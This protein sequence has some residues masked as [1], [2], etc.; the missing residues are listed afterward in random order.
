MQYGLLLDYKRMCCLSRQGVQ[1]IHRKELHGICPQKWRSLGS[2]LGMQP[3]RQYMSKCMV[4]E[5][6]SSNRKIEILIVIRIQLRVIHLRLVGRT[7][8]LL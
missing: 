1:D 6:V 3:A 5:Q 4:L 8:M 2:I 7:K